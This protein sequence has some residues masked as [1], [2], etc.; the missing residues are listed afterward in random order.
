LARQDLLNTEKQEA[1]EHR[2]YCC[3]DIRLR[4]IYLCE[5]KIHPPDRIEKTQKG[6]VHWK[7]RPPVFLGLNR[8]EVLVL[9]LPHVG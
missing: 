6:T 2:E 9:L 5:A 1:A 8:V 4:Q 3:T 7:S